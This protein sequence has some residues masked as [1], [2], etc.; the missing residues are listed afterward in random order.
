MTVAGEQLPALVVLAPLLSAAVVALLPWRGPAWAA[1]MLATGASFLAALAGLAG[2]DGPDGGRLTYALGGWPAPWGIEFVADSASLLVAT[3]VGGL[4]FISTIYAK[5]LIEKEIEGFLVPG[6]YA[7]WLLAVGGLQGTVMTGDAFNLFVFL[8]ISSLATVTLIALGGSRDRRA[9]VAA[10]NYLVI[11]SI[12]A[13]FLVVGVAFCYAITGTLNMAD[14]AARLPATTATAP[15]L[16]GFAFMLAGIMVKA[17]VFPVHI[18]LPAAYGYAPSA[19]STMLAAVATKAALIV[20]ARIVFTVFAGAG[21]TVDLILE[22]VLLPLSLVA[23]GGGT[24]LAIKESNLRKLLAQSS[25]AQI[26]YIT[27]A[28]SLGNVPGATAGFVHIFNH[29]LIKG[30]LFMA[31]GIL[32]AR[33]ARRVSV[34]SL[35]GLGRAMP[36]TATAMLVCGLSLVGMP[37]TA[38]FISKV[39]LVLALVD[40]ADWPVVAVVVAASALSL[41]YLWRIVEAMW[42]RPMPARG[43]V[44][45]DPW[46]Y[47]PLWLVALA[48]V[49]FGIDAGGV[50]SM[51]RRAAVA[52]GAGG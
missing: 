38:G 32:A 28:F 21:A 40:T 2:I 17:A 23:I 3:V 52:I 16:A 15:L 10:F 14:L 50:V 5:R 12:G 41:V 43:R 29:A 35:A 1:A 24:V 11:G 19:V 6:A 27:L 8:E 39:Y 31:A 34:N 30:G 45:E 33:T 47:S 18:W 46:V 25:I 48:N 7:A 22:W 49:W 42:L 4:S 9:L 20:L 13:T 44:R 26:G 51:A 36:V 37:L